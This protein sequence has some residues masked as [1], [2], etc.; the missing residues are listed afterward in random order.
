MLGSKNSGIPEFLGSL[1]SMG[2]RMELDLGFSDFLFFVSVLIF[3]LFFGGRGVC[4]MT[5]LNPLA[6]FLQW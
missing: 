6:S 1:F 2:I 4:L 5:F 3:L